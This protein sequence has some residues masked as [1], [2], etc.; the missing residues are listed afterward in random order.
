MTHGKTLLLSTLSGAALLAIVFFALRG[1]ATLPETHPVP[2]TPAPVQTPSPVP[3][4]T[5]VAAAPTSAD[6]ARWIA[7]ADGGDA[8]RR[9]AAIRAL[10]G[11]PK[12]DALPVLRRILVNGEPQV[13]RP[14]AL[15][16]LRDLALE[17]GDDDGA[18]RDAV[19]QAIYHGDDLAPA[20]EAQEVLEIIEE[21]RMK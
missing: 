3:S 20:G 14:L 2:P 4:A 18:I 8:G 6:V 9:A 19:R 10:A 17:Q 7:D 13:D 15:R 21:S 12:A 16:S 11:A 1:P 5:I